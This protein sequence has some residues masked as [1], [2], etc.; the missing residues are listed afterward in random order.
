M[1]GG[2]VQP[3]WIYLLNETSFWEQH[4]SGI[5]ESKGGI[6][7]KRRKKMCARTSSSMPLPVIRGRGV[8][9]VLTHKSFVVTIRWT[10]A[11]F[12]ACIQKAAVAAVLPFFFFLKVQLDSALLVNF[13][14]CMQSHH[15]GV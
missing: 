4:D 5:P 2:L 8:F 14:D 7:E 1:T 15:T 12:H 10:L 6:R 9:V 11:L 3:N 13:F